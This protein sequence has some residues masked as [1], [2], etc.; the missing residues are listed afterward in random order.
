[1]FGA[2]LNVLGLQI[3]SQS[4]V[5]DLSLIMILHHEEFMIDSIW[6][7]LKEALNLRLVKVERVKLPYLNEILLASILPIHSVK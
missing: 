7:S 2:D 5:W 4:T 6:N 3:K 1:M